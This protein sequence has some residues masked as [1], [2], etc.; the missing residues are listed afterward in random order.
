VCAVGSVSLAYVTLETVA[1]HGFANFSRY[2][3]TQFPPLPVPP[4][5][6][7][8]KRAAH[9]FFTI[10]VYIEVFGLSGE[11]FPT[12]EL[13]L[14]RHNRL[15]TRTLYALSRFRPFCRR[16]RI[17]FRPPAVAMRARNP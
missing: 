7:A 9:L 12:G 16:R 10:P 13:V 15:I 1:D 6:V 11:P 4:D 5:R 17:T 2:G 14:A 3:D 8:D